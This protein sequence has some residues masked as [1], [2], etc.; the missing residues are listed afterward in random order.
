MYLQVGVTTVEKIVCPSAHYVAA[1]R[2]YFRF[3]PASLVQSI[4]GIQIYSI[5]INKDFPEA[6]ILILL[7]WAGVIY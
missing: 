1:V 5:A 6:P 3:H 2:F 4:E 7:L